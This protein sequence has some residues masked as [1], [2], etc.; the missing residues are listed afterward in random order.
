MAADDPKETQDDNQNETLNNKWI[1]TALIEDA[2][3]IGLP[4][5]IHPVKPRMCKAWPF[6]EAVLV[7]ARV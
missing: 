5:A 3:N 6:I 2:H 4:I 1:N 7:D